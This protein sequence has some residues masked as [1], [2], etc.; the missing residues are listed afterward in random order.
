MKLSQQTPE[1]ISVKHQTSHNEERTEIIHAVTFVMLELS[2]NFILSP[3]V[4][5]WPFS[6]LQITVSG[7][8]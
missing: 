1:I 4:K 3:N 5:Y 2:H 6:L 8:M 7:N